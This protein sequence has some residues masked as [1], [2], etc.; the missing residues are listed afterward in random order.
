MIDFE[1]DLVVPFVDN[2]D[3][4]WLKMH[5]DYCQKHPHEARKTDTKSVRFDDM[6]LFRFMIEGVYKFM[7]FIRKI[8]LI[9]SNKEQVPY[10]IDLSKVN[11]VLHKDIIPAKFLPTFNSTTIEM[12][13]HNIPDLAEHFIYSN[14]DMYPIGNLTKED[15]FTEDGKI[16]MSYSNE[17]LADSSSEFRQV[18]H[19]NQ[20]YICN[21]FKF[22]YV[23]NEFIK[24]KHTMTP[25]IKSHVALVRNKNKNIIDSNI[26]AF[27]TSLQHNQYIYPI[28]E[29]LSGNCLESPINFSYIDF[30]CGKDEIVKEISSMNRQIICINDVT[31]KKRVEISLHKIEI[32]NAFKEVLRK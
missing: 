10:Y 22:P 18:C 23:K 15:F 16:K 1:V 25:M 8:H 7:P 19:N 12:F 4:V 29:I 11:I 32:V 9:V 20:L 24:P 3:K 27:R 13:I 21:S 30:D 28:Y 6:G 14:D 26:S 5:N 31:T 17:M 2:K